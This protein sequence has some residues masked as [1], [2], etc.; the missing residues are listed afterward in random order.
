M[1]Q[2]WTNFIKKQKNFFFTRNWFNII[3]SIF[4]VF[5]TAVLIFNL[6]TKN[7]FK[8][9]ELKN[10]VVV[11]F[12]LSEATEDNKKEEAK[13]ISIIFNEII[14][15]FGDYAYIERPGVIAYQNYSI[16]DVNARINNIL[17]SQDLKEQI[18]SL[19]KDC[20]LYTSPSPRDS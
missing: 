15:Q 8:L 1:I 14:K 10:S 2:N 19:T 7:F 13:I 12:N 16:D 20:L 6:T 4:L 3:F 17:S 18:N 11:S 9:S 5:A